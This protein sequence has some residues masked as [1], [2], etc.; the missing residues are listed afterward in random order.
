M[1][2]ARAGLLLW[3]IALAAAYGAA[4]ANVP[5]A[6]VLAP[7]LAAEELGLRLRAH[8]VSTDDFARRV[9]Y[10]WTSPAQVAALRSSHTLLWATAQSSGRPSPFLRLLSELRSPRQAGHELAALLLDHPLLQRR[11]Y[12]WSSPFATV[13]GLGE[14]TY[15]EALIEVV[16]RPE[17]IIG[18]LS[19]PRRQG[20]PL[21][22]VDLRGNPVP[23]SEVLAHPERLAAIFHVRPPDPQEPTDFVPF[24]EYIL[25]NESMVLSWSVGTDALRA[26]LD[27][28]AALLRALRSHFSTLTQK[29]YAASA[30]PSWSGVAADAPLVAQWRAALAFDNRKYRPL[31]GNLDLI[32]A[33]LARYDPTLPALTYQAAR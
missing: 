3:P 17:A 9:F 29:E 10:T 19:R 33:G 28:E 7:S 16:L 31:P 22:F 2:T 27:A 5:A 15:G 18:R 32:I 11:R 24:R 1:K 30:Y 23:D 12:A 4:A 8:Q 21:A 26:R 25:C 14:R 20:P 13:L 6:A